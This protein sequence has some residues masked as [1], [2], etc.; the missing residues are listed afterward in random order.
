M[1]STG[2][3]TL[4][5]A[6]VNLLTSLSC[7]RF[8]CLCVCVC[9]ASQAISTIALIYVTPKSSTHA[10]RPLATRLLRLGFPL[11]LRQ[12]APFSQRLPFA[13]I[14]HANYPV[15]TKATRRCQAGRERE[16]RGVSCS[17]AS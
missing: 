15:A 9:V 17:A 13:S 4:C 5:K 16:R 3:M 14:A 11:R 7:L 12:F 1:G 8:M 6:T 2:R 10:T